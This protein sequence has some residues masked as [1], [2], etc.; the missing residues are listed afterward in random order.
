MPSTSDS[1]SLLCPHVAFPCHPLI[2]RLLIYCRCGER[3]G[4]EKHGCGGDPVLGE[5]P[6][7][8]VRRGDW[9]IALCQA[10]P[11]R[12]QGL[13]CPAGLD[14]LPCAPPSAPR[15]IHGPRG[16][17][18]RSTWLSIYAT[19]GAAPGLPPK[20]ETWESCCRPGVQGPGL[21]LPRAP[22]SHTRRN[23]PSIR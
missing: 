8:G 20:P 13:G 7:R 6:E 21:V 11:R 22:A 17:G 9:L 1:L 23:S 15:T 12:R 14:T 10:A 19:P 4:G 18:C 5:L 2:W 16:S 3:V